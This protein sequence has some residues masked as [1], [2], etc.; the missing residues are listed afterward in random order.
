MTSPTP[1]HR[2]FGYAWIDFFDGTDVTVE[3]E[4]D[5]SI[6]L[7]RL[8]LV[9]VR[10]GE[11]PLPRRPPDGFEDLA[12][13][14]LVTFK[15]YQEAL[16]AWAIHELIGHYV[17]YCK[18]VSPSL[19][20]L[21]PGGEFRLFAVTARYPANL[22]RQTTLFQ[23]S[24][25]VYY[26]EGLG[27][28]VTV[29]V[30]NELPLVENNALLHLF[31]AREDL[32]Q[33]GRDHYQP[34][35]GA[36]TILNL[37]IQAYREDPTMSEKLKAFLDKNIAE[38][39]NSLPPE[40]RLKG[41]PAEAIRNALPVEERLKGLPAEERLKGLPAEERL[42]GLTADEM[43]HALPPEVLEALKQRMREDDATHG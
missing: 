13:H 32:L 42:K 18:R 22:A 15:S 12:P 36:S 16:D 40:E 41:L 30:A 20:E 25:G 8:D 29:V 28:K 38:L 10:P 26:V 24:S 9:I 1:F 11:A 33:F 27:L 3:T 34:H 35:E 21:L 19:N 6:R 5:L 37:L 17:N 14:N 4:V 31:S 2:L 23:L 39:L 43:L 7:Q